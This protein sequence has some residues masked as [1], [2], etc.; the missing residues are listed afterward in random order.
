M[1]TEEKMAD[2]SQIYETMMMVASA[3]LGGGSSAPQA[4]P[5]T[6]PKTAQQLDDVLTKALG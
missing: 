4:D 5:A 6:A 2:T 1:K 3:A